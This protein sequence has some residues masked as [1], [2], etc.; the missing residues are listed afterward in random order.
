MIPLCHK[1]PDRC[2]S[3]RGIR[4]PIC[5]RCTGLTAGWFMSSLIFNILD[6]QINDLKFIFIGLL[7]GFPA[8]ID[9]C[10]QYFNLRKSNN[11]IRLITGLLGGIGI[12]IISN[13]LVISIQFFNSFYHIFYAN[14]L[15]K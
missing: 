6:L 3:V 15:L 13:T 11:G 14:V 5:A 10:T 7:L 9:G 4:F 1:I 2:L 8:F 12:V